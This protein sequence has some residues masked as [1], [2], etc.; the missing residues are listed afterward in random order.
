MKRLPVVPFAFLEE[1]YTHALSSGT[2]A[3]TAN[4]S[5][6]T[7]SPNT[8]AG[9]STAADGSSAT[10][11]PAS[12]SDASADSGLAPLLAAD[13]QDTME[14]GADGPCG[15]GWVLFEDFLSCFHQVMICDTQNPWFN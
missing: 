7:A 8:P 3:S 14:D 13:S 12:G 9:A 2:T 6:S 5:R 15:P 4:A 10:L 1:Q 11:A